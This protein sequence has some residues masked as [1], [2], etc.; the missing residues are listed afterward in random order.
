MNKLSYGLFGNTQPYCKY[1]GKFGRIIEATAS[2]ADDYKIHYQIKMSTGEIICTFIQPE[3]M[4]T[5][6]PLFRKEIKIWTK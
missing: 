4:Y 5:L 6:K 3:K 2:H 1:K